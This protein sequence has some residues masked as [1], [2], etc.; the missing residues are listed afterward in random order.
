VLPAST[1]SPLH[2]LR[3][4]GLE[5]SVAGPLCTRLFADL[6]AD[7]IKIERPG[8]GDFAR[9][10]DEHAQ[11]EGAQFWWLNRGK[12]SVAL[13]LQNSDDRASFDELLATADALVIN[14]TPGATERLGL[15]KA[16]LR[17]HFPRLT[18]CRISGYGATTSLRDRKA[19]D[20]LVQAEA[21]YMS[22]TGTPEAPARVGVSLCDVSTGMYAALLVLAAVGAAK[23]TG[24]GHDL[25]V[26]M[27]DVAAEF[28]GPMLVSYL[29][30]GVLYERLGTQHHAIA[31]YGTFECSDGRV[32]VLAVQQDGEWASF[33]T[34][35]LG[36]PELAHDERFAR[37]SARVLN[38]T[39]IET[40][41][42]AK[43][44]ALDSASAGALL[45]RAD[46]AYG[47]L[48]DMRDLASHP[49]LQERG[50]FDTATSAD[51]KTVQGLRGL[52]S[53]LFGV[54]RSRQRPPLL[55]EDTDALREELREQR[56]LREVVLEP[57][58]S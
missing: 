56:T 29:N 53:R 4:V 48:N 51:G 5:H 17:E 39:E 42:R 31:P 10:W 27:L 33:C 58:L 18:V 16:K 45:T 55:G 9:T 34:H 50:V 21:G 41:V 15:S 57:P 52:G 30:A 54:T 6:G 38:R 19:Y 36:E 37:N 12:R 3:V 46:I 8:M 7:V 43:L 25:D 1:T 44:G 13:D 22:L 23:E 24:I 14:L 49:A 2:G 28:A 40:R 26:A 32:I 35:V 20:M 11:G 47:F